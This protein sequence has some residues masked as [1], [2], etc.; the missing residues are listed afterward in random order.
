MADVALSLLVLALWWGAAVLASAGFGN[1]VARARIKAL[2]ESRERERRFTS[3]VAHELRTPLAAMV[4]AAGMLGEEL[5]TLPPPA[6]RPAEL[7][8]KD[9][10]RLSELVQEL[11]E[12]VV[13]GELFFF[14]AF[15]FKPEQIPFP[16]RIIVFDF[17]I[18]DGADP[19]ESVGKD[20]E[21]SA[22]AQAGVRG[23]VDRVQKP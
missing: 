10:S 3:D 16:G 22:I 20:P 19:G 2:T 6:R 9:V 17:E 8:V 14:P 23:R 7:L 1:L 12:L 5:K 15:L 4:S 18:H 21:Q 11:L 13:H